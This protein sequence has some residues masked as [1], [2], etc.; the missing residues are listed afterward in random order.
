MQMSDTEQ[1]ASNG[2]I[3]L[4]LTIFVIAMIVAVAYLVFFTTGQ[5]VP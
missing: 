3:K 5:S 1:K 4:V 2:M